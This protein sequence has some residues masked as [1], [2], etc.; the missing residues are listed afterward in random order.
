MDSAQ[1]LQSSPIK[2][3]LV[4]DNPLILFSLERIIAQHRDFQ[5]VASARNGY[6]ALAFLQHNQVD[7]VLLDIE[8][9][10]MNGIECLQQI[11]SLHPAIIVILLTT[12]AEEQYIIDGLANGA[13]SYLL[14]T[15]SFA[16]LDQY[17]RDAF[18]GTFSMPTH[19]ATKLAAFLQQKK[20]V[21]EKSLNPLFFQTYNLTYSEQQIVTLLIKRLSNPEIAT[22]LN[23]Q[24]GTVRNHL[25]AI[26]AKLNVQNRK[27]A[28]TL[29]ETYLD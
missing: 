11:R 9:P 1:M 14:K 10:I 18:N 22:Q 23:I 2:I 7:V 27:E 12:F 26:F 24:A 3:L 13:Q 8:M 20:D 19:V 25:V 4:D 15:M 5:V 6:D 17:I 21:H 29:I 16:N 28:A